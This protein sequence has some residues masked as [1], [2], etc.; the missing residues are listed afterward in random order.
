M[1]GDH[2]DLYTVLGLSSQATQVEI[3]RAYRTLMRQNHPDTRTLADDADT[4]ANTT[5][6]QVI[7]AYTVLGDPARRA[8]YDRRA[9][10]QH[11]TNPTTPV[12]PARRFAQGAP[13]EPPIRAGP[14]V[15]HPN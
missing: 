9:T 15:W 11:F 10:P 14:V 6:Q 3:R 7:A 5:A 8:V 13:E 4:E 12:R 2:S 1:T